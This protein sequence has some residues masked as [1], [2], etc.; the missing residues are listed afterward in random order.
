MKILNQLRQAF[1]WNSQK[2][3]QG[4]RFDERAELERKHIKARYDASLTDDDNKHHWMWTDYYSAKSAN[5][6]QVRR[7]LRMRAR[8]ES[9]NNSY[10]RGMILTLAN[11]TIGT[12]PRL[13]L[14]T[15]DEPLDQRITEAFAEWAHAIALGEKLHTMRQSR[16]VDGE[17]FGLM[18]TNPNLDTPAQLDLRLI[19][20]DQVSSPFVMPMDPLATDGLRYDLW[21]NITEYHLLKMHPG[22]LIQWGFP[23]DFDRIPAAY[24][25]H[26]FRHDRPHQYRGVP[27]ITPALPL[28]AQLRRYTL[29]VI[30]AAE[31]AADFAAVLSSDMPPADDDDMMAPFDHIPLEKRM[32]TTLPAGYKLGQIQSEQPTTTYA[33][34]KAE[35]LCE[36]ARCL[37]MPYNIAAGNSSSYNYSSGR[38]DHQTFYSDIGIERY[39]LE[40]LLDR[41]FSAW[42]QEMQLAAPDVVPPELARFPHRWYWPGHGHVDPVKEA[43]AQ[44]IRLQS[45]TTTLAEECAREGREWRAVLEQR[46]REYEMMRLLKLPITEPRGTVLVPD[47]PA[48]VGEEPVKPPKRNGRANGRLLHN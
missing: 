28:F 21:D 41:L 3:G 36:I 15:G 26:W 14:T 42:V 20:C 35:I 39:R 23:F 27:D 47:Q 30:A 25:L 33:E 43:G 12:G 37:N 9:A 11:A 19:E 16:A 34:F 4:A 38:L 8:Y 46:A 17:A 31:T 10:C 2:E 6:V 44:D 40:C 18:V 7:I 32:M 13:Q 22:D 48:D 1:G 5:I 29:A 24:M 45:C